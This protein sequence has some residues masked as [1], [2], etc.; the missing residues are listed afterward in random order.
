MQSS[1]PG[2]A[3]LSP[4]CV[5]APVCQRSALPGSARHCTGQRSRRYGVTPSSAPWGNACGSGGKS[6]WSSLAQ[7]CG[8]WCTWPTAC[9]KRVNPLTQGIRWALSRHMPPE[10]GGGQHR[11]FTRRLISSKSDAEAFKPCPSRDREAPWGRGPQGLTKGEITSHGFFTTNT[12]SGGLGQRFL[13]REGSGMIASPLAEKGAA[14]A[15]TATAGTKVPHSRHTFAAAGT[16]E[17]R[18]RLHR[19]SRACD[20]RAHGCV[21]HV[22]ALGI[23]GAASHAAR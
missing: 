19:S 16:V 14:S 15:P 21:R 12:V 22:P 9:S 11:T 20:R 1:L 7:P 2:T 18:P 8:N 17:R 5:V 13:F 6:R 3:R 4:A 23:D 10:K